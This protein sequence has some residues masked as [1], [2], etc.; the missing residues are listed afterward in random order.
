[1]EGA[2]FLWM[3]AVCL[4]GETHQLRKEKEGEELP[5]SRFWGGHALGK[6]HFPSL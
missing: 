2:A 1:M 6:M 3:L 5:P 4:L